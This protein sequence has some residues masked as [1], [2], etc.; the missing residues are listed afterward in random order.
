MWSTIFEYLNSS[1]NYSVENINNLN[2]TLINLFE[3]L[4]EE[5]KKKF[6]NIIK[7]NI[8]LKFY[9]QLKNYI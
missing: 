7:I 1:S 8:G 2:N 9:D 4:D 3:I 6:V 5:Q